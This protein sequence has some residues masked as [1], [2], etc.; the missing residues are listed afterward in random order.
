MVG[1]LNFKWSQVVFFKRNT[2]RCIFTIHEYTHHIYW[3]LHLTLT[4]EQLWF[5]YLIF[6]LEPVPIRFLKLFI[7]NLHVLSQDCVFV[8]LVCLAGRH[9][10]V[11]FPISD[12]FYHQSQRQQIIN[13]WA[14]KGT[15]VSKNTCNLILENVII[16]FKWTKTKQR[17]NISQ[18]EEFNEF[19]FHTS[20]TFYLYWFHTNREQQKLYLLQVFTSPSPQVNK[21]AKSSKGAKSPHKTNEIKKKRSFLGQFIFKHGKDNKTKP[22]EERKIILIFLPAKSSFYFH[23]HFIKPV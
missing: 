17:P 1:F 11:R 3:Y 18:N 4:Y 6:G 23:F 5:L 12:F 7:I 22:T 16:F 9:K 21:N 13:H 2:Y 14:W 19:F 10:H 8:C 15:F 20:T